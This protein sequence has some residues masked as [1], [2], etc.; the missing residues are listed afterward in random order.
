MILNIFL[1]I[2]QSVNY[3]IEYLFKGH[4]NEKKFYKEN[5]K[6][7]KIIVLD[8]GSNV[9][10]YIKL[11]T[12]TFKE[13]ELEIHSFEPIKRLIDK[14]KAKNVNLIKNNVLVSNSS[15]NEL[16]Y[17]RKI[18]SQSST[19][20]KKNMG[21][22]EV[23]KTYD[24]VKIAINEYILSNNVEKIDILK[25]DVEGNE[26]QIIKAL[27]NIFT[28]KIIKIIKIESSVTYFSDNIQIQKILN[29]NNYDFVGTTN[30]KYVKNNILIWD[31]F[32][33]LRN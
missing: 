19:F 4:L 9:G 11:I 30:N 20:N 26:L 32:F 6:D 18:S 24:V 17:E 15:G 7:K 22:N 28:K 10:T 16:F 8:I 25:I 3:L 12:K 1:S 23:M 2:F 33:I 27:E 31:S 14:Q 13:K 29:S 5:L 21:I